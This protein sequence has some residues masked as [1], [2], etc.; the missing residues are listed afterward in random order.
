MATTTVAQ[1]A[2]EL[3]RSAAALLE[4]LQSAGV[5]KASTDDALTESDKER[6]LD[7]LRSA[8]GTAPGAERKKITLTR[9]STSEIKQADSSGKARTIQVE[10]RKKRTFIKRDDAS[11]AAVEPAE[12]VIDDAELARREIEAQAQAEFLRQ[13]EADLAE[14]RRVREEQEARDREAAAAAAVAARE[15][16]EKVAA[17]HAAAAAAA[18]AKPKSAEG[19]KAAAKSVEA[20]APV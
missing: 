1:L 7:H 13:Q 6:L 18:A 9:K 11:S 12:P 4:Q 15:A 19:A 5:S 14:K 2:A 17:E 8:H 10:V 3:N 16:A 20:P